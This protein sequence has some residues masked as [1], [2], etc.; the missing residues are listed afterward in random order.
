MILALKGKI[1]KIRTKV[2]HM[3][4]LFVDPQFY[5]IEIPF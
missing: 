4:K 2:N 5:S 1:E 3:V